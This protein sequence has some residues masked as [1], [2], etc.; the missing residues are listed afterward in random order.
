MAVRVPLE[1]I[2]PTMR[3]AKP[4]TDAD[5]RLLAGKGTLLEERVLRALRKVAIQT[6]L[7]ED[8]VEIH[9]WEMV[10]TRGSD[11][12]ALD[13]RFGQAPS[14]PEL[15][16]LRAAIARHIERRWARLESETAPAGADARADESGSPA[17]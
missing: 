13:E 8:S 10:H 9:P 3:L 7:V 11:L 14:T 4:I 5:G 1:F 15:A 16:A 6:V 17:P 12:A 2:K